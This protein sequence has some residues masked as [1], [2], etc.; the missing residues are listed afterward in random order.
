MF[1]DVNVESPKPI[2]LD[3]TGASSAIP[4]LQTKATTEKVLYLFYHSFCYK[5]I[6][7]S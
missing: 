6:Q 5:L 3:I 1:V 4:P 7:I 2:Q